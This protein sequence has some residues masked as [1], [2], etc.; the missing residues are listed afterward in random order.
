MGDRYN[1]FSDLKQHYLEES[2]YRIRLKDRGGRLLILAP[3]GG[4]IERGTSELVRKIAGNDLSYYTFEGLLHSNNKDL[5]ITSTN[6]D[7]PQAIELVNKVDV[8]V[9]VHG[10]CGREPVIY[11]GG[12]NRSLKE[13]LFQALDSRNCPVS[14]P[15][16]GKYTGQE[17]MNVCNRS[18]SGRGVQLEFSTAIRRQMFQRLSRNGTL[19]TKPFFDELVVSIQEALY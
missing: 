18:L 3:H 19:I 7:E 13:R 8:V 11:I 4:G 5:H 16:K 14:L 2:D 17:Y 1:S 10:C 6:F 12:N 9:V 15:M